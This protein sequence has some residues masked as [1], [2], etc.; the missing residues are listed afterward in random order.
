MRRSRDQDFRASIAK[1]RNGTTSRNSIFDEQP[2]ANCS[3]F[4][5]EERRVRRLVQWLGE[6]G[7]RLKPHPPSSMNEVAGEQ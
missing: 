2:D 1:H 6:E 7:C 5:G 3:N 4:S